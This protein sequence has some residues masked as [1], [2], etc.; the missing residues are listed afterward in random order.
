MAPVSEAGTRGAARA[1]AT[2]LL[3]DPAG[4]SIVTI[5]AR[6]LPPTRRQLPEQAKKP[7]A[8]L[9]GI[10]ALE[11]DAFDRGQSGD[12]AE[13]GQPVV[14]AAVERPAAEPC[15][16]SA[17]TEPVARR[18]DV[19]PIRQAP[20]P[21]PRCGRTPSATARRRRARR[22]RPGHGRRR[23][24]AE[25]SSTSAGTSAAETVAPT[26]SR[27]AHL[28]VARRLPVHLAAVVHGDPR[29]HAL[30]HVEQPRPARVEPAPWTVSSDPGTVRAPTRSG[31]AEENRPG[32]RPSRGP[33]GPPSGR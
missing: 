23:G 2:V 20:R 11:L 5:M 12:R 15:R 29:A 28:H 6:F 16:H 7:E 17:D 30:E 8:R 21:R 9:D 32:S 18:P 25:G 3:P 14:T 31:A 27:R 19:P 10:G 4:P 26:S 1:A 22:S 13:H 24:R 33:A